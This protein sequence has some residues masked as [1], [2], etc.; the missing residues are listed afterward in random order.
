MDGETGRERDGEGERRGGRDG[1]PPGQIRYTESHPGLRHHVKQHSASS[2]WL[3]SS[4]VK[5]METRREGGGDGGRKRGGVWWWGGGLWLKRGH[6]K[7][8]SI[9]LKDEA[10]EQTEQHF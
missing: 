2:V 10:C 1:S 9:F 8:N 4:K 3:R 5:V 7:K 6:G